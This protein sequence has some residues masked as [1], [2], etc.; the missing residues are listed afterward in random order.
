M[1]KRMKAMAAYIILLIFISSCEK[2]DETSVFETKPKL[3]WKVSKGPKKYNQISQDPVIYN[4]RLVLGYQAENDEGYFIYNKIN[5]EIIKEIRNTPS[6]DVF[7]YMH[8]GVYYSTYGPKFRTINLSNFDMNWFVVDGKGGSPDT[9]MIFDKDN[10]YVPSHSIWVKNDNFK[11]NKFIFVTSSL[12][13]LRDWVSFIEVEHKFDP[14]AY[15]TSARGIL[16]N[17]NEKNEDIYYFTTSQA[18]NRIDRKSEHQTHAYNKK[19]E[20][21]VWQSE[22]FT[23]LGSIGS[24]TPLIFDSFLISNTG[25]TFICRNIKTGQIIWKRTIESGIGAHKLFNNFIIS[26][27]YTNTLFQTEASTGQVLKKLNIG[28][29]GTEKWAFHNGIIYFTIASGKL[30]AIDAETLT[31]K[32]ELTS[33]N[34][35]RCSY[36]TFGFESPVVDPETNRIYISDDWEVFC[37]E[38]PK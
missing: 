12:M 22:V 36:C 8:N 24:G 27:D 34:R 5:G 6:F 32:W 38:L 17:I 11:T 25:H 16:K 7:S 1:T 21:F 4:D 2:Q 10:I 14:D 3:V 18:F 28:A 33:P 37:Y 26:L 19:N 9:D 29:S 35:D 20:K 31:V 30:M 13:N 15:G 23:D